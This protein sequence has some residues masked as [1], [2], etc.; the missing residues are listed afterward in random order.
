M[1]ET[2]ALND[3]D[4]DHIIDALVKTEGSI[5]K[6]AKALNVKTA[7]LRLLCLKQPIFIDAALE[8]AELA[9]DKAEAQIFRSLRKGPLSAR[10]QAAAFIVKQSRR[11][12]R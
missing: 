2:K 6:A 5:V 11:T 7:D 1:E 10:L 4:Q 8:A 12:R 3:I 9:L